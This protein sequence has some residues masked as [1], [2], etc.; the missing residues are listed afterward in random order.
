MNRRQSAAGFLVTTLLLLGP[1]NVARAQ[2]LTQSF[3]LKEGWNAIY[4]HVDLSH[5]TLHNLIG[6]GGSET[7]IRDVWQWAPRHS[8]R[9]FVVSP[10]E[11]LTESSDWRYWKDSES[12]SSALQR[13]PGNVACL[14]YAKED[15]T[16][17]LKGKPVPPRHLWS[18]SGLN[19]VGFPTSPDNPPIFENFLSHASTLVSAEI[20]HYVGGPL[21]TNINPKRLTSQLTTRV[22]RGEAY[23]I[24]SENVF[25][26]HYGPFEIT[27]ASSG[28]E[29][30]SG[31]S[32]STLRLRNLTA[33][34]VTVTLNLIPS[35]SPPGSSTIPEL[36]TLIVRGELNTTNL[37]YDYSE[38]TVAA[39]MSWNLAAANEVGSEAEIVL[40]L[41][42]S[43]NTN[44]STGEL[45]AGILRL[46]DSLGQTQQDLPVSAE[47]ADTSGLWVGGAAVTHVGQYLKTYQRD[48]DGELVQETPSTN[49]AAY[50][51][52]GTDTTMTAVPRPFPLRLIVHNSGGGG[53][54]KLLQRVFIG[55]GAVGTNV[56]VAT[57]QSALD[58]TRL[59]AAR[60]ITAPHLPFS[61]ANTG[62]DQSSGALLHG[63]SLSF[64]VV[65]DYNDHAANPFLHTFHPDHDN[66]KDADFRTVV[67]QG[68]ESYGVTRAVTL[69]MTSP[70]DDFESLTSG[71]LSMV[72]DYAET[73]T[74]NGRSGSAR[75]FQ[76]TG[77]FT[78][79]R[80]S[81]EPALVTSP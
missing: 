67:A 60:R 56:V 20:Y 57:R 4:L 29:F 21:V 35:E 5:D 6:A 79:N 64:N 3:D 59:R 63:S 22:K 55:P 78:L 51:V 27:A 1:F 8:T 12:S 9:Q 10:Q 41:N 48:A 23:W 33:Q 13:L 28:V 15:F 14:V 32:V 70:A 46:T 58:S 17:Q 54:A 30:G 36:P 80:I 39:P 40:G 24:D 49:G 75:Q 25:N 43:A 73:I 81:P 42:R 68:V 16:L 50:V 45:L 65:L 44:R 74:F 19:F 52:T 71:G 76:L 66:L 77:K 34:A 61:H 38:L 47:V 2:W 11:P 62:W 72:G 37:S 26:N 18:V 69:Q 7:R 53:S 31:K